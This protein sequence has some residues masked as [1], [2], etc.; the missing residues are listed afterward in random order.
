MVE[1]VGRSGARRGQPA[2]GHIEAIRRQLG[3]SGLQSTVKPGEELD[4]GRACSNHGQQL[5]GG[6]VWPNEVDGKRSG[7]PAQ[8]LKGLVV[9]SN[10]SMGGVQEVLSSRRERDP[11][12]RP[13]EERH[14][15]N[16]L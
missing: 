14:A 6:Q 13:I 7:A 12:G 15:D 10:Q 4:L 8:L 11:A 2:E 5:S 9:Q 16:V 3:E 1:A